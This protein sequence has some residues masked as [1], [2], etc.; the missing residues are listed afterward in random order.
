MKYLDLLNELTQLTKSQ[1]EDDV[2]VFSSFQDEYFP[3]IA[4]EITTCDDVLH[5]G[6]FVIVI[7]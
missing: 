3:A 2:T 4:T 7:P 5:E 1:L 6:H